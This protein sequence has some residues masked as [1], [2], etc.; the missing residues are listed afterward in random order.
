[1]TPER[2]RRLQRILARRQH[3]LTV[4]MDRVHKPHNLGAVV[5]TCDAVGIARVH[6]VPTEDYYER[7]RTAMGASRYVRVSRHHSLDAA[8]G[9]L[10]ERGIRVV[11][12]HP[13]PGAADFRAL[14]YTRPTALLLGT[15]LEGLS[16]EAIAAADAHAAVPM[17]GAVRSLNVSVAAA[18]I[19]YEAERQ[20]AR[21]GFYDRALPDDD[22]TRRTLF[23]WAYPRIAALCRR[24]GV[25]YPRLTARGEIA[26]EVPR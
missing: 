11:A 15:E 3:D 18:I 4:L 14:D 8:I 13:G 5:R 17:Y 2:F 7:G 22:A 24:R 10:H 23:E 6:I 12:A 26:G 21:A 19:L 1:M 25:A 20:R 9:R 16:T